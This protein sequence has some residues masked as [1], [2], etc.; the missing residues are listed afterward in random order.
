MPYATVDA[1]GWRFGEQEILQLSDRNRD[2]FADPD[3]LA[4]A[5]YDADGIVNGIIGVRY[6]VPVSPTP[7]VLSWAACQL[8]RY[9][10]HDDKAPERVK[11]G[12]DNA[13]QILRDIAEGLMALVGQD[14]VPI[15]PLTDGAAL[16]SGAAVGGAARRVTAEVQESMP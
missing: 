6:A 1:L 4:E 2:G 9:E 5:I 8:A 7:N 10:L 16:Y 3:V 15:A 11:A 14:G 13:L 12:R